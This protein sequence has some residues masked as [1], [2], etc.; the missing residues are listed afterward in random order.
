MILALAAP[1]A[2]NTRIKFIVIGR[3]E[4]LLTTFASDVRSAVNARLADRGWTVFSSVIVPG[5][6]ER[7]GDWDYRAEISVSS[8]VAH[9]SIDDLIS[10]I[11]GVF[12]E[13]A[14]GY[15]TVSAQGYTSQGEQPAP[16]PLIPNF[17]SGI[18]A[19]ILIALVLVTATGVFV[20]KRG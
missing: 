12:W 2:A 6:N 4:T 19:W 13:E 3:C 18:G 8:P 1:I 7:F 11:R 15:P 16:T 17:G 5:S 20:A 9:A 10:V 14:G